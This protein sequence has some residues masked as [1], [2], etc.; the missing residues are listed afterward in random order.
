[1]EKYK[2][3][4]IITVIIIAILLA[5]VSILFVFKETKGII[6]RNE[7]SGDV[8]DT[9]TNLMQRETLFQHIGH[10]TEW[11]EITE[12]RSTGDFLQ[13]WWYKSKMD[14]TS[15]VYIAI[16]D[17]QK[18]DGNG[19]AEFEEFIPS[20]SGDE[21]YELEITIGSLDEDGYINM[22]SGTRSYYF[23]QDEKDIV[24]V[25]LVVTE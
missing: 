15:G 25:N 17:L 7:V 16:A 24:F 4:V 23:I 5:A 14:P 1:M 6:K 12:A 3:K 13:Q 20:L 19:Y 22:E 9:E 11:Y 2:K 8:D 21:T 10:E 18:N